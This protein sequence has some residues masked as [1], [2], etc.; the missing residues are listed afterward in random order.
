[1]KV[2]YSHD[3][4]VMT[5]VTDSLSRAT[6]VGFDD[7][8]RLGRIVDPEGIETTIGYNLLGNITS[9]ST[10]PKPG[11]TLPTVTETLDFKVAGCDGVVF[12]ISCYRPNWHRDGLGRQ[13]DFVYN[14]L[15]QLTSRTD[16]ADADGVRKKT[17]ITWAAPTGISRMT[18]VQVC[19]DTAQRVQHP[20]RDQVRPTRIGATP[21]CP[22]R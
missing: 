13:T 14:T 5:K 18:T 7:F 12:D 19:G 17:I 6:I 22:R 4:N 3:R 8:F 10:K 21:C 16:P 11:S 2:S 1:M 15:G 9:K 20:Q